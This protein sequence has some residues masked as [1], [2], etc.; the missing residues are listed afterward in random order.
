MGS[1]MFLRTP[2]EF[3]ILLIALSALVAGVFLAIKVLQTPK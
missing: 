1:R 2:I 3:L